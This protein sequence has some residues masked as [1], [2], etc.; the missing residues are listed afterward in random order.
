MAE[1]TR[2][3][4]EQLTA[5]SNR[6]ILWV[7]GIAIVYAAV[8]YN[9]VRDVPLSHLPLYI[10]NK[11]VALAATVLIGISYVIGPLARWWPTKYVP[12]LPSRKAI[13]VAGY[14]LAAFHAIASL[15]L[16]SPAYYSRFYEASGKL[17]GTSESMLVMGI[18]AFLIFSLVATSSLPAVEEKLHPDDWLRIQRYGLWAYFFVL[19]HVVLMG[20]KGW[21]QADSYQ[22]GLASITLISSL[23]IVLVF[24]IRALAPARGK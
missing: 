14:G 2:L 20:Y 12:L 19:L 1:P 6:I 23:V 8:R 7:V 22:Y 21:S 17:T 24:L 13:G 5:V 11:A 4:A 16:L 15:V 9:V 18:L 10:G 3:S